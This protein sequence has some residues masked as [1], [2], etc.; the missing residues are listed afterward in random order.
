MV[1]RT[2][3]EEKAMLADARALVDR[4]VG[5]RFPRKTFLCLAGLPALVFF[6]HGAQ[7]KCGDPPKDA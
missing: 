7:A 6:S 4:V 2:R 3:Y 5:R 1:S